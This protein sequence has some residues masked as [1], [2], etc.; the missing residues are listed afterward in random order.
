MDWQVTIA[1]PTEKAKD[2]QE[3]KVENKIKELAKKLERLKLLKSLRRKK[4]ENQ[5]HFFAED[6]DDFFNKIKE[7]HEQQQQEQGEETIGPGKDLTVHEQDIWKD[8]EVEK[9]A[10]RYWC[11]SIQSLDALL[12]TRRQWDKYIVN[13]EMDERDPTGKIPPGFVVPSPPANWI[14]ATYL[15]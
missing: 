9:E 6:G 1:R 2:S 3:R 11:E 13:T 5:G 7:S 12:R 14:W 10:Y 4:L 15:L 8:Q